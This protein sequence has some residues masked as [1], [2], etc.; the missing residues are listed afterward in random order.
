[1]QPIL[2]ETIIVDFITSSATGAAADADS[3]P[4]CEVFE[5]ATDTAIVTPTVTKRT[6]KTGNYRIPIVC[7][8]GNGF[9]AGKSYN[10]NVSA[11]IGGVAAKATVKSFILRANSTDS[12]LT[13]G[14]NNDKAGY[15]IGTGGITAASFA[16]GAI[17][18]NAV[19]TDAFGALELAASAV[20]EIVNGVLATAM[21]ESY[22]A[23]G[24]VPTLA[25]AVL[26]I[27]QILQESNFQGLVRHVRNVANS[28]DVATHTVDATSP[29]TITRT[30]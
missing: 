10:V 25:Q 23:K 5:D 1:M 3:A 15:G 8:A 30:T 28:A 2:G 16:A 7:T 29:S 24:T 18:A 27:H 20:T 22:A 21:S 11:T 4:T 14:T 26:M 19:A 9:E 17:D 12:A 13:V 6:G